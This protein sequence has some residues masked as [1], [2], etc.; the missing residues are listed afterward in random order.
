[1]FHK[2]KGF[3]TTLSDPQGRPTIRDFLLHLSVRVFPVGR[4]DLD[5]SGLLILTNDGELA[6]RLM[7]PSSLV[8]KVYRAKVIGKPDKSFTDLLS[9][10][11]LIIGG[12][13][14]A[15]AK[16]T[17]VKS[18]PD[19]GYVELTLTEGRRHQVKLMCAAAGHPVAILKRISYGGLPLPEDLPSGNLRPLDDD[20][21]KTLK[22][23][24][25][26]D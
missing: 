1:M 16:A 14:A 22:G 26:L 24:V 6:T 20:Q 10:G 23:L 7:H 21:I 11:N 4:L 8:P 25:G 17:I 5:V 13:P 18:G 12:K 3:V 2:P 9:S 19:K 15:P